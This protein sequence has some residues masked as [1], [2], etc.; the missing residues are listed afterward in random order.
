M[1][2]SKQD[3]VCISLIQ[4]ELAVL[5]QKVTKISSI[6]TLLLKQR[7]KSMRK[8]RDV[9]NRETIQVSLPLPTLQS[10]LTILYSAHFRCR[11]ALTGEATSMATLNDNNPSL[12]EQVAALLQYSFPQ[13]M[14]RRDVMTQI[15]VVLPSR[16]LSPEECAVLESVWG[17]VGN[18][19]SVERGIVR[20]PI[21]P[22][23]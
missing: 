4:R 7:E 19:C 15:L 13:A 8:P 6:N 17:I 12:L 22:F 11:W 10:I 14:K 23:T 3:N 5:K 2:E 18:M 21:P 1:Q 9:Q 20:Y 16:S